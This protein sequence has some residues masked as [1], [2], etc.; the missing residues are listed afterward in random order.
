MVGL[1][2]IA[3]SASV[4]VHG[5]RAEAARALSRPRRIGHNAHR[6]V[7]R[8]QD[9]PDAIVIRDVAAGQ[10]HALDE[11]YAR[12]SQKVYS[13]AMSV[14]RDPRLAEEALQD[15]FVRVWRSAASYAADRGSVHHWVT[16]IAHCCAIDL[17]RK[18]RNQ[19]PL[20]VDPEHMF[21][22]LE[23]SDD[24]EHTVLQSIEAGDVQQAL[25]ELPFEQRESLELAYF[26]GYTQREIA[27]R[28]G[29]PLGTVKTRMFHALRK[30]RELLEGPDAGEVTP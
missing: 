29:V 13:L 17:V 10:P 16:M 25:S 28:Q 4:R 6:M 12:Y 26:G 21:A 9:I 1:G 5:A 15:T 27:E 30:M 3:L 14:L 2:Y 24:T 23:A 18:E 8:V 20:S 19:R 11:L 7:V 22:L